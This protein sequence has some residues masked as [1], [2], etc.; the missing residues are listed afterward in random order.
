[1]PVVF[2]SHATKDDAT[3]SALEA[4]LQANGCNDIFIDHLSVAGGDKWRDAVRTSARACRV[5][6]CVVSENWLASDV[7]RVDYIGFRVARTL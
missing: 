5:V 2:I 1:M 7:G 6:L 4:W 3:A